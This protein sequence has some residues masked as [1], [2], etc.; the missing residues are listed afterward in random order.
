M[1]GALSLGV[2][3]GVAHA[4]AATE[5]NPDTTS[6]VEQAVKVKASLDAAPKEKVQAIMDDLKSSLA[7][8]GVELPSKGG[9]GPQGDFLANL[10]DATKEKAQAIVDQEK[11][12][13]ITREEAQI[14][15]AEL[16]VELPTK[17]DRGSL[18]DFLAGLD[19]ETRED[20]QNLIDEATT[21]LAELRVDH[22]P[23]K[24]F[25]GNTAE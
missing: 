19:A 16:G 20:A 14:Q 25:K 23:M 11:D 7:T 18:G 17:G 13:T 6:A 22:L 4:F 9:H 15:L 12:G 8:I 21:Q 10:D 5:D 24:D 1:T 3:G 2:I